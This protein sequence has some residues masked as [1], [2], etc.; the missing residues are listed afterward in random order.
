MSSDFSIYSKMI[1]NKLTVMLLKIKTTLKLTL[2]IGFDIVS[3]GIFPPFWKET[4]PL[5]T[6][7]KKQ[8]PTFSVRG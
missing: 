1:Q 3:S 6:H 2:Y 5:P 8:P 7:H 4:N